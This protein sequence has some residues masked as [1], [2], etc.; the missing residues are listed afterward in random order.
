MHVP[1]PSVDNNLIQGLLLV[2]KHNRMNKAGGGAG[3]R[4]D[5]ICSRVQ[6]SSTALLNVRYHHPLKLNTAKDKDRFPE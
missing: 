1:I 2:V 6:V 5:L 3:W 4:D